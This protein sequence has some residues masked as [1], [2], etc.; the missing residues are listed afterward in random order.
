MFL[1]EFN[2][3]IHMKHFGWFVRG[4]FGGGGMLVACKSS[5]AR[6]G[7]QATAMKMLNP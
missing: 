6:D 4:D 2:E 3:R 5:R 1:C 7:T